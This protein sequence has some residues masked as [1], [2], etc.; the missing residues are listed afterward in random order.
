MPIHPT[1]EYLTDETFRKMF[2]LTQV[3]IEMENIH[4]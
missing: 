3:Q 2:L 4:I 1:I